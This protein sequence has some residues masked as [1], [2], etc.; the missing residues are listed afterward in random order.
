MKKNPDTG[1]LSPF[2][3]EQ[4]VNE[5][6]ELLKFRFE[7][8]TRSFDP[9]MDSSNIQ[10]DFWL[11]LAEIIRVNYDRYDGFVILHGTDTMS[12]TASALSFMI[13]NLS[14]PII[15]TGSQLP[16]GEIRT[17]GR[18]NL[19]SALEVAAAY[20]EG[21]PLI[22][23][24]CILFDNVLYRGNRTFKY[25]ARSFNAFKSENYPALANAGIDVRYHLPYVHTV[26]FSKPVR[27]NTNFDSNVASLAL[28]PGI[29]RKV[30]NSILNIEGLKGVVLET[31]GSGNA[32][33]Y[34]WFIEELEAAINRGMVI[35]NISQ[36][37]GGSVNM[38]N[39]ETG[40]LL[41]KVGVL[42]GY[43]MTFE[44]AIVKLMYLFG[45]KLPLE[46]I[47]RLFEQSLAG[48]MSLV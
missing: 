20:K 38:E 30:V 18:E 41:K 46:D 4:I 21:K 43:D 22:P 40:R 27:F 13:E 29:N 25:N 26:D 47:K 19:L 9:P 14:K 17:D 10:P 2:N 3:F 33:T 32:P 1:S 12:Y 7:L 31:F 42:T 45:Q 8:D 5:V 36:C 34:G 37:R 24:V 15:L 48:E 23:E 6:P 16:I 35:V 44:A 39:Y 28:F 11:S